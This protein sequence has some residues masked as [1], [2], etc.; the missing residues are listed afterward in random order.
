MIPGWSQTHYTSLGTSI[1]APR[2]ES[3]NASSRRAWI[4]A[5]YYGTVIGIKK[6]I[7][8]TGVNTITIG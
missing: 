4:D 8:V 7:K 1:E 2:P 6:M 5:N 3:C